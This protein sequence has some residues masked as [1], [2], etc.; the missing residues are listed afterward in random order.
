MPAGTQ[1]WVV[2]ARMQ[3][4]PATWGPDH[5]AF[6]PS[7]FTE[8]AASSAD[9]QARRRG[10][11]P[12]SRGP[13]QCPGMKLAQIEFVAA[14][15]AVFGRARVECARRGDETAAAARERTRK[16]VRD[17]APL[18]AMQVNRPKDVVLVWRKK[19]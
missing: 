14:V 17:S 15:A 1:V 3:Y 10:F 4:E 16:V 18:L 2:L 6:R 5:L 8:A 12:W 13:R 11:L 7:R 9:E 19:D